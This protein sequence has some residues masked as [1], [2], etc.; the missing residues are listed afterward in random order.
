MECFTKMSKV[1]AELLSWDV[2]NSEV[3]N[4]WVNQTEQYYKDAAAQMEELGIDIEA[5][6]SRLA[7]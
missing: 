5:S 6:I 4:K 3:H 2:I 7:V 1:D